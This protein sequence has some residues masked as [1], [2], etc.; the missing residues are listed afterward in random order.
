MEGDGTGDELIVVDILCVGDAVH[1]HHCG[2]KKRNAKLEMA[3][4]STALHDGASLFV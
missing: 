2:S 4:H 3:N 1:E